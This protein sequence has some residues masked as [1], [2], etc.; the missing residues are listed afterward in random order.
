MKQNLFFYITTAFL[1]CFS[2]CSC[3]PK[4]APQPV[5]GAVESGIYHNLLTEVCGIPEAEVQA[6]I[7]GIWEHFFTPGDFSRYEDDD[8]RSVYY[9]VGDSLAYIYDT[10]SNDV[11]TEGMSYGMMIC[12]QLDHRAEFDKLWRWAKTYMAYQEEPWKG[13][14]CWQCKADGTQ[15]GQS[16][17][18]DGE[19]YFITALYMAAH[20]WNEPQYAVEAKAILDQIMAKDP[21][22]GV[23]PIIDAETK[24]VSFVPNEE[25]HW[26]GDP[27]YC[28]PAFLTMWSNESGVDAQLWQEAADAARGLLVSSAHPKT[29]LYP[30]YS[31]FD[32]KPYSW[33]KAAYNTGRYQYDAI[34]CPMNVGMDSHWYASDI[35]NQREVM[36]RF[37]SFIKKDKFRH[38]HFDL[39][40]SN[41]DDTY[42]CGQAAANAVGTFALLGSPDPADRELMKEVLLHLWKQ[43]TPT[44][45]WRYYNGMVYMLGMLHVSG[46]FKVY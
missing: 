4:E 25:V 35:E 39:D 8:Q 34:R 22:S 10:G 23:Y 31:L 32:G 19:I 6:R 41:A 36:R 30:D 43:E 7:E 37:L 42:N 13:Y 33:P 18:S 26:F 46:N 5:V 11:R 9:E 29:G 14:F 40:G 44:G 28:L 24:L 15:F 12:V 3:A 2:L 45:K 38:G 21:A 1:S 16:N 27:S 17:A 20:R